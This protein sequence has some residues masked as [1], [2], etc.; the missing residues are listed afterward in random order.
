[1]PSCTA[2]QGLTTRLPLLLPISP[3]FAGCSMAEPKTLSMSL[4]ACVAWY[5]SVSTTR[6]PTSAKK[7]PASSPLS[8]Q[9]PKGA[10]PV[11]SPKG[12]RGPRTTHPSSVVSQAA[13]MG[14]AL[15][16]ARAAARLAE[17]PATASDD[18][19]PAAIPAP[20][21][22][23][24][25]PPAHLPASRPGPTPKPPREGR[26]AESRAPLL[27]GRVAKPAHHPASA[28]RL[29]RHAPLLAGR[30][31]R[32]SPPV[33]YPGGDST[34]IRA[35][36]ELISAQRLQMQAMA[37]ALALVHHAGRPTSLGPQSGRAH[38]EE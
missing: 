18:G 32:S 21:S 33:S 11:P 9:G 15:R 8:S 35:M 16:R 28:P 4:D 34:A 5:K 20:P 31:D 19:P 2:C 29:I 36:E 37:T 30:V 12:S 25:P 23:T 24:E 26:G 17:L 3:P 6:S 13:T 10:P 27:A 7:T 14:R 1:M 38:R 22:S